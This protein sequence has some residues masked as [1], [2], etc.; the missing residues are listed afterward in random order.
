MNIKRVT[1]SLLLC[2]CALLVFG[3]S[4]SFAAY[5]AVTPGV[6]WSSEQTVIDKRNQLVNTLKLNL[7]NPYTTVDFG[8]ST[9]IEKMLPVTSLAKVE[10]RDKHHVVGAV[11]ASVYNMTTGNISYLLAKN[12]KILHLGKEADADTGYMHVPAAIGL[13]KDKKAIIDRFNVDIAVTHNNQTIKMN[14]YNVDREDNN[15]V[16]YT[17]KYSYGDTIGKTR[18]NQFGYEVVIKGLSKILDQEASFGETLTGK[19]ASIRPYGQTTGS[20]IPKDGFVLSASGT[21]VAALKNMKIGDSVSVTLNIDDKWKDA[22]FMLAS[23]PLL[24]QD[25]KVNITVSGDKAR[26]RSART[27]VAIDITGKKV[28]MVTVDQKGKNKGM[29]YR[30]FANLLIK[31]GAYQ[32]INLDGGGSTTMAVRSPWN[33]YASLVNMPTY[34]NQRYV[35]AILEAI[36]T[37]PYG[38]PNELQVSQSTKGNVVVGSKV[39]FNVTSALDSY[40]NL[41]NPSAYPVQYSV[42]GNIGRMDNSTFIAERVGTGSVVIKSG[43]AVKKIPVTVIDNKPV[44]VSSLDSVKQWKPASAKAKTSLIENHSSL[45]KEGTGYIGIKYDFTSYKSSAVSASYMKPSSKLTVPS[46]PTSLSVWVWADAK[47]HW[48][49][50]K[51]LDKNGKEYTLN[52]TE[53]HKLDWKGQWKQVKAVI[54]K[55]IAYPISIESIYVAEGNATNKNSGTIYLDALMAN[56]N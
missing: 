45:K 5:T 50:T 7:N 27:A 16:L 37:A 52:F 41:L 18:T 29:T 23:G 47:K 51:I 53:E 40:K 13:T 34:G 35:T 1:S 14:H 22:Q 2:C 33:R 26:E 17:S 19:V 11:N 6:D 43:T 10:T 12:N 4:K 46:T 28:F 31:K 30:E 3:G 20:T 36:S 39:S 54:P 24:V 25:G 21:Q 55:N 44:V 15:S 49:R 38:V 42:E 48:L 56:Y 9:P 32:A 8:V